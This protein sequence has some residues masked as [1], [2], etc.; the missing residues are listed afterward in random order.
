MGKFPE[1]GHQPR[2]R[3]RRQAAA[4]LQLAA[5][6]LEVLFGQAAFEKRAGVH[7]GR[8]VALEVDLVAVGSLVVAAEEVVEATSYS[9]ADEANVEMWPPMPSSAL[10][11]RTTIAIAF[12]RTKLLMRRSS[13]RLPG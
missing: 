10:F 6:V 13:S 8:G 11:A 1:L 12:Q 4:W 5:E 3:I 9:V 7:A 2:M